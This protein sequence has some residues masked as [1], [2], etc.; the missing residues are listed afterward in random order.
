MRN[1]LD[2]INVYE[3]YSHKNEIKFIYTC[4]YFS[5]EQKT[6]RR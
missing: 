1:I 4:E 2:L 3:N 5:Q 6:V